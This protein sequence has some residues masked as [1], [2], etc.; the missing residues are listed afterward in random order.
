MGHCKIYVC[1]HKRK[2]LKKDQYN[3]ATIAIQSP[4][5]HEQYWY[6]SKCLSN[7]SALKNNMEPDP[8]PHEVEPPTKISHSQSNFSPST[9]CTGVFGNSVCS[10]HLVS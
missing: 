10:A 6:H 8:Q 1:I 4:E 9:S 7:Y 5:S 3:D 2:S